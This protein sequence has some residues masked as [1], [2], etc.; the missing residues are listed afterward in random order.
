MWVEIAEFREKKMENMDVLG[1]VHSTL[2]PNIVSC[3]VYTCECLHG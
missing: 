1:E 2:I 3:R